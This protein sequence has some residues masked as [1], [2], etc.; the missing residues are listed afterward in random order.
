MKKILLVALVMLLGVVFSFAQTTTG[1]LTGTVSS[2]DGVLPNA[3]VTTKD[4]VTGKSQTVSTKD[5]G[6]FLFPQL[7]FGNYTVTVTANGFKTYSAT[8]VKIDVGRDYSL[9]V[10]L[11]I[12]DVQETVT[13]TAG[14]DVVTATSA[15]VSNTISPQQILSLPLIT[16]N[17][18]SLTTLQAGVASNPFQNTSINGMRTTL[19]NITRDGINIQDTFIRTNATDFAPGRPSVD[20]TSEFTI[21][22]SNQEADQG[23]GGA[24][25]RLVTPRGTKDF[26]GALFAYNRNSAFS[27]NNFFNNR[28]PNNA[29]G[30]QAAIAVKPSF[31]NRNQYGGKVSGPMPI[32]NFGEG[33]PVFM[34]DKGFFF[35]SFEGIKDPLSARATRTILTPTA[36]TGAF[37]YTRATTGAAINTNING[38]NVVC[39]AWAATTDP[40]VTCSISNLLAFG[41]SVFGAG[42]IAS[43]AINSTI[44]NRVISQ[45]PTASNLT[46]GDGLNTAG[47]ALNRQSNQFR[48]TYTTREDLDLTE[49]DNINFVFSYNK[50]SNLRPDVDTTKF[51]VVPGVIQSSANTTIVGTYRRIFSSTVVNEFKMGMF[52]SE[53]PFD[54]TDAKP[55][56]FIGGLLVTNPENTFLSQG[57]NTKG[58]NY[59]DNVDWVI[60]KHSLRF[61]GQLQYFQVDAYNEV[62][63]VPTYN[64]G[65]TSLNAATNTTFS[66]TN[67][68]SIGGINTTQVGTANSLLALYG[69]II[70]G[71][72]Q[73]FN[74][75]DATS[76][77]K[78]IPTFQPFRYANHSL[79]FSDRWSAARGLTISAGVRYEVFPSMTLKNGI[80]LEPVISDPNNIAASL[81]STAG[82]YNILGTNAGKENAY[83][84]TDYDNFAP[85]IGIAYTPNFESGVMKFLTGGEGKTVLRAGYSHAYGNDSIVTSLNNAV[86]SN[87]GFGRTGSN[88][89]GPL[90]NTSLNDRLSGTLTAINPPTFIVPP[91]TFLQNNSAA[92]AGNFGTVFAIDPNL[93]IPRIDQYSAGIQREIGN[94]AIEIRYVGSSS[95]NLVRGVDLNQ[96]DIFNNGFLAD[97]QRAATN[98]A[99][100]GSAFCNPAVVAGCQALTIFRSSAA[101]TA[102]TVGGATAGAG[103]LLVGTGGISLT[104]FNNGLIGGAPAD[105]ALQWVTGGFNN[106][107]TVASPTATPFVRLLPN[108]GTGV[109]DLVLND[110]RYFYNSL[111]MEVRR[112]FSRGLYF[113]A[114]YSYSKNL[115]DTVGTS[116]AL[117]EPYLDNNNKALDYQLAD[118]DQAHTFNFNGIYQLPFGKGKPFLNEGGLLDK[119]VGGWEFSSIVQWGTGS[120]ITFVDGRGTFNRAGRAGRQTPFTAQ[121]YDQIK[122]LV[123]I[124]ERGGNIYFIN[125]SIINTTGRASEGFGSTPF[126]GQIFFNV[127]PGQTGNI[128]RAFI[129]GPRTFNI[130]SAL[131]KNIRFGENVKVQLRAEA[132]NL[133]NNVN[134][135]NNTQF[136]TITS[137][138]FGQISSAGA[139]RTMQFAFRFEF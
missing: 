61:G 97:Y 132:F 127:N 118:F 21:S 110:G 63:I 131:L 114:N 129:R 115:T 126:T 76:G 15:Q 17:P 50:E 90:G 58:I 137:T 107:P 94:T 6:S 81:L 51:T 74:V 89:I 135:F 49:K 40:T 45:L 79:Y 113:Q 84:K 7:E 3:T 136:A 46:G 36:R 5:D 87:V 39:P 41:Q 138:T 25:I 121:T 73:S 70:N 4:T 85:S 111:Q 98:R 92:V 68:A 24:Q 105:L 62:G 64:I 93:Q 116:Q 102:T 48:D 103:T 65:T 80:G 86:T 77:F 42:N 139:A 82:T 53:V 120:P 18:L 34:K 57:R 47:F 31:R 54:R 134:L 22:L 123:G 108:P 12:G 72:S 26:H 78:V 29:D 23:Y 66:T 35:F 30:T 71:G 119:I 32:P 104:N 106:H 109:V 8:D 125:P 67:F 37:Q 19:T 91:R 2:P 16:R 124:F 56:F 33:G 75:E 99:N 28:T 43:T 55:D 128:G 101:A 100:T 10:V 133:L 69:G 13:V 11:Q 112:R 59:Q 88:A 52:K 130:N 9:P 60:G 38:A 83:Y 20:D 1:R 95:K 44:Q 117:F 14:A 96:I 122:D 27:A